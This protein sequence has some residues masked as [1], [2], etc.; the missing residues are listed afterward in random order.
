MSIEVIIV[1]GIFLVLAVLVGTGKI[2]SSARKINSEAQEGI[3]TEEQAEKYG[4]VEKAYLLGADSLNQVTFEVH[5]KKGK[6]AVEKVKMYTPRYDMLKEC[7]PKHTNLVGGWGDII[8]ITYEDGR[9][10]KC[11]CSYVSFEAAQLR[12]EMAKQSSPVK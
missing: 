4:A 6:S 9:V 3:V 7:E 11:D 5:Y 2:G 8:E 10:V 12:E 1:I